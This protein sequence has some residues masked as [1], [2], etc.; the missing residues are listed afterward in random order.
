MDPHNRN[1]ERSIKAGD[2]V[3]V[4]VSVRNMESFGFCIIRG[5]TW[6]MPRSINQL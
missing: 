4:E 6:G 3:V 2:Y 5:V 1:T